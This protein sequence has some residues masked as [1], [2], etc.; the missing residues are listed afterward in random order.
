MRKRLNV[1]AWMGVAAVMVLAGARQAR[2][3]EIVVA[4]VPFDFIVGNVRLPAGHYEVIETSQP[5]VVA[6]ESTDRRHV[7]FLLTI[8]DSSEKG[9]AAPDLVFDRLGSEHFLARIDTG[10]G[11]SRDI[12][13]TP[14]T[15]ERELE[16]V[17]LE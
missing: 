9:P 16:R 7:A 3:D 8:T 4:S 6:I 11:E 12:P 17:R 15:M 2:A 1:T 13:L 14:A 5:D 10:D